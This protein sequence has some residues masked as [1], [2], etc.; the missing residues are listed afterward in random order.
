MDT[1]NLC[2]ILRGALS[3]ARESS[4]NDIT[5]HAQSQLSDSDIRRARSS[6]WFERLAHALVKNESGGK[7]KDISYTALCL[8]ASC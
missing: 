8:V 7:Q 1:I 4:D 2:Q 5:T 6:A 3:D